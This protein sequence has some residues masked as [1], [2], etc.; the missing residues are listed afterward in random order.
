[1]TNTFPGTD[2]EIGKW[3]PAAQRP[4]VLTNEMGDCGYSLLLGIKGIGPTPGFYTAFDDVYSIHCQRYDDFDDRELAVTVEERV[5][6]IND[7]LDWTY[8]EAI[9]VMCWLLI[10]HYDEQ[11]PSL[12]SLIGYHRREANPPIPEKADNQ[13]GS[14]LSMFSPLHMN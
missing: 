8:E 12:D 13:G 7:H 6:E 9:G 11:Q 2:I 3:Y 10:P 14:G 4:P 1:M 5:N